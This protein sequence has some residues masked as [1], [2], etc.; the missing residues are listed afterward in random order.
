MNNNR[1][2]F[3]KKDT[4]EFLD[5]EYITPGPDDVVVKTEFSTVSPGTERANITG[6]PNISSERKAG[7]FFPRALGYSS[8]GVVFE[9]GENVTN[10][11]IGDRVVAFWGTH[12]KYNIVRKEN[13]VKIDDDN[14]SFQQAAITFISSFPLA[15]I[16]KTRLEVGESAIVMGLGLLGQLAVRLLKAAG[17]VPVIAVDPVDSRREEALNSGADFALSPFDEDFAK[18]IKE[19]TNGGANVAIEVTGVGAGLDGVLDCMAKFGRVALL[20]CTRDKN[21]TI[22]YYRK[23]HSPGITIVG[24]HTIARPAVESHPGYFTHR[25]DIK[26]VMKLISYNRLDF[27]DMIKEVY[28]PKNCAEVYTRLINDKDFPILVQFDWRDI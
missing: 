27:G 8:A 24:A 15:A 18:K 2:V 10:V 28:S 20:G 11:N 3:T 19:I 1:I 16:R 9:K 26:S 6:D 25:D 14:I 21:F 4:A 5:V 7:T 23:I 12:S 22:D 13:I 17:A